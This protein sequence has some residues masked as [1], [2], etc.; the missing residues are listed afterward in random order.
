M[1]G[2]GKYVSNKPLDHRKDDGDDHFPA[3]L[4]SLRGTG[5]ASVLHVQVVG[6]LEG[7]LAN[8]QARV[9]QRTQNGLVVILKCWS[10]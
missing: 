7:T 9:E 4:R 6:Y 1:D 8:R 3:G 5:H 10:V 2:Q